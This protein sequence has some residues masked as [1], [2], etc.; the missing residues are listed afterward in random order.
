MKT[1][2]QRSQHKDI[3]KQKKQKIYQSLISPVLNGLIL[4]CIKEH[5]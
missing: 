2:N 4:Q 3:M 5:D 1:V